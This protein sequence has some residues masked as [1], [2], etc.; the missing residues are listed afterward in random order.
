VTTCKAWRQVDQSTPRILAGDMLD[1]A[2]QSMCN[3]GERKRKR[4]RHCSDELSSH[5]DIIENMPP[6]ERTVMV[7]SASVKCGGSRYPA[8]KKY[9]HDS[10]LSV[11][12]SQ[13]ESFSSS[14]RPSIESL[15]VF[16]KHTHTRARRND[17]RLILESAGFLERI[18]RGI[19]RI[20]P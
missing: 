5:G 17:P 3:R 12:L 2:G 6:A 19:S 15:A 11:S 8:E 16:T 20:V 4:D 10:S 14:L 13:R 18:I 1:P 9:A 7:P